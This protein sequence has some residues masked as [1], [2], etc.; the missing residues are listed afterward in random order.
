[1]VDKI[2]ISLLPPTGNLFEE[3]GEVQFNFKKILNFCHEKTKKEYNLLVEN[4]QDFVN[5]LGEHLGVRKTWK[6]LDAT[7]TSIMVGVAAAALG[8]LAY[9]LWGSKTEESDEKE[10]D[11]VRISI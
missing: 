2:E 10:T 8:G 3:M 4:C 11:K 5:E 9:F 1:I 6:R 7:E